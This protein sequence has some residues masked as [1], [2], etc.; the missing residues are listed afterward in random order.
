MLAAMVIKK[1]TDIRPSEITPR[2][3]CLNRR[4]WL[5][6]AGGVVAAL[7]VP[8]AGR[9]V[10]AAGV[11]LTIAKRMSTTSDPPN[12]FQTV[13]TFNNFYEFGTD[14]SD[15]ARNSRTRFGRDR[16]LLRSKGTAP[17]LASIRSKTFSSRIRSRSASTGIA[18]SRGGR[19]SCRGSASHWPIC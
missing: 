5:S 8:F 13:T 18:A 15:P 9:T 4:E 19:S 3:L 17:N 12:A 1:A 2:A 10:T 6:C 7:A 11:P 16:G 14:K